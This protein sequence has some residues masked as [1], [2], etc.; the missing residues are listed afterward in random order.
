MK[1]LR[2][3]H[4]LH[5]IKNYSRGVVTANSKGS[6]FW[7]E[8]LDTGEQRIWNRFRKSMMNDVAFR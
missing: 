8:K 2:T 3:K 6:S 5:V 4:R 7:I 1:S